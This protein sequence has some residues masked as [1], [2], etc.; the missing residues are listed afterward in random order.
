MCLEV[1]GNA[2]L[3]ALFLCV[4]FDSLGS[5]DVSAILRERHLALAG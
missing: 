5:V 1:S 3:I 2:T 4:S